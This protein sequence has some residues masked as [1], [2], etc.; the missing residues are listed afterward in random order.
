MK[1]FFWSLLVISVFVPIY[2][3]GAGLQVMAHNQYRNRADRL[4]SSE[5][6][7]H[8]SGH[9][10]LTGAEIAALDPDVAYAYTD[11]VRDGYRLGRGYEALSLELLLLDGL[12][13]ISS[14]VGIRACHV[15]S[16]SPDPTLPP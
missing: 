5:Q 14:I 10:G 16:Q 12:L 9:V 15:R 13:F 6:P 7:R 3:F 11:S 8:P 2:T 1:P 4:K